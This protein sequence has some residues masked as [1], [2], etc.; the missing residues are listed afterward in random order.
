MVNTYNLLKG[1]LEAYFI[2]IVCCK[3]CSPWSA[4]ISISIQMGVES[5]KDKDNL[6]LRVQSSGDTLHLYSKYPL[7]TCLN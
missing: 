6:A 5:D 1:S 7:D 3:K 2:E 4:L